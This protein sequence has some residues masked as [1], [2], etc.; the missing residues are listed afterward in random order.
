MKSMELQIGHT[1]DLRAYG[2]LVWIDTAATRTHWNVVRIT[3]RP[4]HSYPQGIAIT[5]LAI[6]AL[7]Y[8]YRKTGTATVRLNRSLQTVLH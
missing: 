2:Q 3:V 5:W 8:A 4:A 1:V 6:N 7:S